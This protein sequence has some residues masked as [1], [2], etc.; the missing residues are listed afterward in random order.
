MLATDSFA[1]DSG[2]RALAKD[3][4]IFFTTCPMMRVDKGLQGKPSANPLCTCLQAELLTAD[5]GP[6]ESACR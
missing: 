3:R 4:S 5:N 6:H 2:F 1:L